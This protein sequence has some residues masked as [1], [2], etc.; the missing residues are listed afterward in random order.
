MWCD[1]L[2][3]CLA[4]LELYGVSSEAPRGPAFGAVLGINRPVAFTVFKGGWY[5]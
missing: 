4:G 3:F 2:L 5:R 1:E